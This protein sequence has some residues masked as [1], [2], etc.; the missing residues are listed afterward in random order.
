MY[1]LRNKSVYFYCFKRFQIM[2]IL[3][4]LDTWPTRFFLW[5]ESKWRMAKNSLWWHLPDGI[6]YC[7]PSLNCLDIMASIW[8]RILRLKK[9]IRFHVKVRAKFSPHYRLISRQSK[10]EIKHKINLVS[11][12]ILFYPWNVLLI[13]EILTRYFM[14]ITKL[15]RLFI[16]YT[17]LR[18]YRTY[19]Y[20]LLLMVILWFLISDVLNGDIFS[21]I[22]YL[23]R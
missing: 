23:S 10:L 2:K 11:R 19:C 4:F 12:K 16:F 13:L 21:Y 9:Q 8:D 22:M 3:C 7:M 14:E 18:R 6:I 1:N 17:Y 5:N 15:Y 20:D